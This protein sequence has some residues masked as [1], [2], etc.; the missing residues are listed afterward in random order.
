MCII[1]HILYLCQRLIMN[2]SEQIDDVQKY[3]AEQQLCGWLI[4]DFR[5]SNPLAIT[6]LKIPEQAHLTR[7]YFY[8]IP[9][10]GCPVKVVHRIESHV[11]DHLPGET[12]QYST[13]VELD[14]A[15]RETLSDAKIVAME[16]SPNNAIPYIS[17]VDGGVIDL[18]RHGGVDVVSSADL[19][20]A[21]T[22]TLDAQQVE[23]HLYATDVLERAV[24]GAWNL[25]EE[26]LKLEKVITEYDVQQFLLK[27][28]ENEGC[29]TCDAPICAVNE[30]AADPHYQPSST[31]SSQINKGDFILIDL[32]CKQDKPGAVY[33]DITRVGVAAEK[34][35]ARQ[36]EI[37]EIVKAAR[38]RATELVKQRFSEDK[39][40]E[41]WEVDKAARDVIESEGY[42][43]YYIHRTGHNIGQ[44]THGVGANMDNYETYDC[45]QIIPNTC[46]S[47]EPGIYLPGEFGVRL[48]YD[49]LVDAQG[50]V[51]VTGGEQQAI[52]CLCTH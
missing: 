52:E 12:I 32:W 26:H 44:E 22:A 33:G 8:W 49:V 3:L 11:L 37:F 27:Y 45:R 38:D 7:R 41:G 24:A 48:E 18:V 6:V 51:R 21:Y 1:Y 5:R 47:I 19:L 13:W 4:Y 34:P 17:V 10:V 36:Q 40:V 42:G 46:F 23:S 14:E 30:H 35:T 15:I 31:S 43:Q 29:V 39:R 16:Y 50:T 2:I 25:I 20:Q 9:Q 28:F